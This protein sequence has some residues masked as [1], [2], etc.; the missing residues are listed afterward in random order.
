MNYTKNAVISSR[1]LRSLD[2]KISWTGKRENSID[3]DNKIKMATE[4][5]INVVTQRTTFI[6]HKMSEYQ[7]LCLQQW[8]HLQRS[9]W[10]IYQKPPHQGPNLPA[11]PWVQFCYSSHKPTSWRVDHFGRASMPEPETLWSGQSPG[12]ARGLE[13]LP[14]KSSVT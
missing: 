5:T 6:T 1:E 4:T 2:T 9:G 3:C 10:R 11:S 8:C 13:D 14:R 7:F 12:I